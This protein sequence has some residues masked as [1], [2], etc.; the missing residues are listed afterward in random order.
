MHL[1]L[2]D[3][4]ELKKVCVHWIPYKLIKI[5]MCAYVKSGHA[6][7]IVL[8]DHGRT[9]NANLCMAICLLDIIAELRKHNVHYNIILHVTQACTLH[10][11]VS[12][13]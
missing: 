12:V 8:K 4:F 13:T 11:K 5:Q 9:V 2:H 1:N 6:L 7:T 3:N 10:F